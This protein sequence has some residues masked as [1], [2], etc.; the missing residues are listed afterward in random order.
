[1]KPEWLKNNMCSLE[2]D[3][4]KELKVFEKERERKRGGGRKVSTQNNLYLNI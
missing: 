4:V 1:M 3:W 2:Q